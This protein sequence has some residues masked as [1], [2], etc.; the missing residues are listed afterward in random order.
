MGEAL[1]RKA[2]VNN[3]LSATTPATSASVAEV[4]REALKGNGKPELLPSFFFTLRN[5]AADAFE[6][7][8]K[9]L[10]E[11][12]NKNNKTTNVHPPRVVAAK[13][14]MNPQAPRTIE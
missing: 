13:K 1:V 6:K 2:V 12:K 10:A 14:D 7:R 5:P 9:L 4:L 8:M 11:K 3:V